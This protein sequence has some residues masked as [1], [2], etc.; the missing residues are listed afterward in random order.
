MQR[1]NILILKVWFKYKWA[2]ETVAIANI[3]ISGDIWEIPHAK[4]EEK[5]KVHLATTAVV[6]CLLLISDIFGISTLNAKTFN[7]GFAL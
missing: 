7:R 1:R 6:P 5:R 4:D 3:L 2:F